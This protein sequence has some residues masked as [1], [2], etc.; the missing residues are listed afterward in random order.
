MI[1]EGHSSSR[2]SRTSSSIF[3]FGISAGNAV[4]ASSIPM[5]SVGDVPADQDLVGSLASEVISEAIIRA[6]E[7]AEGAYGYPS[8]SDIRAK[9]GKSS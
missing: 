8:V 6:V 9:E 5:L 3:S 1:Q 7:S 4:S 2:S